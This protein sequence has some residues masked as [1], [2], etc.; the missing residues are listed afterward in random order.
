MSDQ[1]REIFVEASA[2]EATGLV[3][4]FVKDIICQSVEDHDLC[5]VAL[6]GGTT[7]H[8]LYLRLA[9]DGITGAVPWQ[10]VMVFFGDERD[11]PH[12][13]VESNFRMAQR[14]LLDHVPIEL[15][16]VHPMPADADDLDAAAAAYE[17]SIRE[18]VPSNPAGVPRLDL[19]LLGM[20]ID[21]HTVS[22]FP[23]TDA[24]NESEKLVMAYFVP[25]LGR[26][27]MTITYPLIGA[28]RNVILFVT[29]S[30]K[31]E[32]VG[33]LFGDDEEA[34]DRLPASRVRP[35]DGRLIVVLD[36]AAARAANLG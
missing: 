4:K 2:E 19:I 27:R 25:V 24:L 23:N 29:G 10:N 3:S 30:D 11:V 32:T 31:A 9:A 26:S 6:A 36:A 17:R 21:G 13:H 8:G 12:D 18:K 33:R 5:Y 28:A 20:G 35:T 22:L 14:T 16:H 15:P 7:P 1:A 34:R